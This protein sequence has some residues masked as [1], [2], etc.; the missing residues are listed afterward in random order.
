MRPEYQLRKAN[1]N[2]DDYEGAI[3]FLN[4]EFNKFKS[5][6]ELNANPEFVFKAGELIRQLVSDRFS[7]TDPTDLIY[8]R[9]TGPKLG[10]WVELEETINTSYVV[11]RS[12]GGKPRVFTPHKKKYTY[13]LQDWRVDYGFELEAIATGQLDVR[14]WVEHMAEAISRYHISEGLTAIDT[15]CATGVQDFYGRDVRTA[16]ATN[17][18]EP[19]MDAALRRLGDTNSNIVIFG[20]YYALYPLFKIDVSDADSIA[21]EFQS[22]G[23]VGKYRGAT[24]VVIPDT[25][26]PFLS[27]SVVPANR[28]YLAGAD[29][30]GFVA[31]T[32]MSSMDYSVVDVEEQHFR[33]GTKGRTSFNVFKPQKYHVV[34]IT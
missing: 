22:R 17:V 14:V 6:A 4:T 12:L 21:E 25:P 8:D 26:N 7:I 13:E 19:T 29:K 28:I 34:E 15:A 33:V 2:S 31:E 11:Q 32:D 3:E 5:A 10:D 27:S 24:V 23:A 18:D 16:V 1:R 20:R 9:I 30:G